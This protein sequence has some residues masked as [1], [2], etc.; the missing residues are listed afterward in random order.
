MFELYPQP[1]LIRDLWTVLEDAR[2][3]YLL[4]HEYP[5]LTADLARQAQDAIRTHT[6][7]QG[8]TV[9]EIV[10]DALLLLSTAEPG[11]FRIPDA[12]AAVV[13]EAWAQC[14]T[15]FRPTATAEDVVRLADRLYVLLDQRLTPVTMRQQTEVPPQEPE[16]DLGV[17][18]K[19]S[20]TQTDQYRP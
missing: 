13:E 7:T 3:E 20:E 19:A 6:L 17:G 9:R 18:P 1:G 15:M 5:G 8:M 10:V 16:Q 4:R 14:R 12:I 11:T 2:V